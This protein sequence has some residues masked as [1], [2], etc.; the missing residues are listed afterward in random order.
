MT[1]FGFTITLGDVVDFIILGGAVCGA[2]YKIWEFFAKPT[3]TLKKRK[4]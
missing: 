3:S 2:I 4:E 1:I